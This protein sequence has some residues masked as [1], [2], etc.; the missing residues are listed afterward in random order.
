MARR[1]DST[2]PF[3]CRVERGEALP[4]MA[5]LPAFARVYGVPLDEL[6]ALAISADKKRSRDRKRRAA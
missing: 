5:D 3:I 6:I 4:S 1:L 2:Q